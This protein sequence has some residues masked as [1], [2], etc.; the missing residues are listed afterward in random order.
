MV[1]QDFST[2]IFEMGL[3]KEI[4]GGELPGGYPWPI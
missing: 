2:G 1:V 4:S 3:M